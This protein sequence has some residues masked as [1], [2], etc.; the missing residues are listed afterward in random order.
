MSFFWVVSHTG[1]NTPSQKKV[2]GIVRQT[3]CVVE[4]VGSHKAVMGGG[5]VFGKVISKIIHA[6]S[7]VDQELALAGP[8]LDPIKA[9]VDCLGSFLFESFIGKVLDSG[10]VNLHRDSWL[11]MP[12]F[13]QRG[14]N[15]HGFCAVD[16]GGGDF[17]FGC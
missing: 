16:V 5:M 1:L 10:V 17:G 15:G 3:F 7:P 11:E 8:V 14:S 4:K 9:H 13:L 2:N 12:H 6:R